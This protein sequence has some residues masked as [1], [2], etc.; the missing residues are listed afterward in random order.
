MSWIV[1]VRATT[2]EFAMEDRVNSEILDQ[3]K[4]LEHCFSQGFIGFRVKSPNRPFLCS[5]DQ[6]LEQN[7]RSDTP[8]VF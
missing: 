7:G 2:I 4:A 6:A 5:D 8:P 1:V 3:P